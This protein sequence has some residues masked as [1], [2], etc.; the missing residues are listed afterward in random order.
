[1]HGTY[2]VEFVAL[3]VVVAII[4]SYTALDLA[5]RVSSTS[6]RRMWYW[7]AGGAVGM[8]SGIWSMHFIGM[9][10]FK[11]PVPIA[12]DL[13]TTLLSLA[14]AILV[15]GFALYTLR[16]GEL[17]TSNLTLSAT[18]MGIGISAM[19]Y[20]GMLAMRMSPPIHYKPVLFVASVLI[21]IAA[22]LAALWI[23]TQLRQ[24]TSGFA[25]VARLGSAVIMGFAI[26]GMHYTGMAAAEFAPGSICLA[27]ESGRA[28]DNSVL[29]VIVGIVTLVVLI[30]TLVV[31]SIDAQ[32]AAHTAKLA[33]SLQVAN[34]ELRTVA[35]YDGLTGLPN[36]I[37]FED[38]V[39]QAINRAA[40]SGR[41]FAL[42]FVDLDRFKPV[43]DD[44]G[45]ATGDML[46]QQVGAR[47]E[48]VT[49]KEDTVARMGGDEF[50][51]LLTE[52]TNRNEA[53]IVGQKLL[54]E[55]NRPFNV[56]SHDIS[57]SGS[58]G[59]SIYP[60]DGHDLGA[61]LSKADAA[62]YQVKREGRNGV[63]FSG[64]AAPEPARC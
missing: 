4:A 15:S 10:A 42:M 9:L 64:V 59:V 36:R 37:L 19:H 1:M 46:L 51:V 56:E 17:T 28:V 63:T 41:L 54:N 2:A 33:E 6:G 14:I 39:R 16:R 52:L 40:R 47:L 7:L 45:H 38:R 24:R 60:D 44:F 20:T 53:A 22:S 58:I 27:A 8:G 50:V 61:L 31:S 57:V 21:A 29:A 55:L 12:F 23:A 35:L 49:R 48:A 30:G 34:Q 32:F 26:T 62:M 5:G 11:L 13:P 3:S 18:L 43:N 25:I